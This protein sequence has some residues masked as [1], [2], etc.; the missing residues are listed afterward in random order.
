MSANTNS[1]PKDL[2]VTS[3]LQAAFNL[4]EDEWAKRKENWAEYSVSPRWDQ[5]WPSD[6]ITK[7][8][9]EFLRRAN[10][11]KTKATDKMTSETALSRSQVILR[12]LTAVR[13]IR[14]F[15]LTDVIILFNPTFVGHLRK[16]YQK[17]VNATPEVEPLIEL[18]Q[19]VGTTDVLLLNGLPQRNC[20][21][22]SV[23]QCDLMWDA[24]C[25]QLMGS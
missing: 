23:V 22:V 19:F 4:D 15:D 17:A 9:E 10:L 11:G 21:I 1:L 2:T 25:H 14:T 12:F 13:R 20:H 6:E 8:Q 24:K 5:F 7:I 18:A 3:A 16:R